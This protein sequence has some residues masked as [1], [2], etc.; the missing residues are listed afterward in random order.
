MEASERAE[1]SVTK[2]RC[3]GSF[4]SFRMITINRRQ[5][6]DGEAETQERISLL[7]VKIKTNRRTLRRTEDNLATFQ[8][9]WQIS[10]IVFII[11]ILS[12]ISDEYNK[13]VPRKLNLLNRSPPSRFRDLMYS[14]GKIEYGR[15]FRI[16]KF[17]EF[18]KTDHFSLRT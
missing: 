16:L 14:L 4:D 10:R 12:K 18:L 2:L 5:T 3:P 17:H 9:Y 15:F 7:M 6:R 13:S 8:F 1:A 11:R